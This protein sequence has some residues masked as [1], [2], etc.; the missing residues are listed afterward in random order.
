MTSEEMTATTAE[1]DNLKR[2]VDDVNRRNAALAKKYGGDEKFVRT[3]KL[4]LRTPPPLTTS[5]IQMFDML[6][7]VKNATD[8]MVL[9]NHNVLGNIEYFRKKVRGQVSGSCRDEGLTPTKDQ[10]FGIAD[11][12]ANEYVDEIGKAA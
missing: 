10:L 6:I 2:R 11:Y 4:A 1:L 5:N 9:D 12:I 8:E 7:R 3:H